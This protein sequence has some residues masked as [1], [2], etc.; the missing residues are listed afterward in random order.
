MNHHIDLYLDWCQ[1]CGRP[2]LEIEEQS[3]A[4]C[5]G[6]PLKIHPRFFEAQ[7]RAR[8]IFDP[9]ADA[10]I[11]GLPLPGLSDSSQQ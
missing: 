4:S 8:Q 7:E 1:W 11:D 5:D 6:D 9:I 3:V 10:V 2:R